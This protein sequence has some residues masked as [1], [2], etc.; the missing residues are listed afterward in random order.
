MRWCNDNSKRDVEK[1]IYTVTLD[2]FKAYVKLNGGIKSL[3]DDVARWDA[4]GNSVTLR[5]KAK[6]S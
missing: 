4:A 5:K 6:A 3:Q 1:G 2:D